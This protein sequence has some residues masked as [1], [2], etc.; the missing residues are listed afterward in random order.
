MLDPT[1]V[2][3]PRAIYSPLFAEIVGWGKCLPPATLSN[4]DLSTFLDTTDDW[5]LRRTGIRSR[6]ISHAPVSELAHVAALH[7]LAAAGLRPEDLELVVLGSCTADEQMPNTSSR[8]QRSI[9]AR[10]AAAVDVNTACT[11]FMYAMSYA[12]ALIRTGT[13]ETALVVGADT[14]SAYMDWNDRR[15]SVVFGDGAGAVVLRATDEPVGILA[16]KLGC[17]TEQRDVLRI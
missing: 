11:S 5:I 6:P 4:A 14:L 1:P 12:S 8:I 9:G 16:E 13:I 2:S 10:R 7:A 3:K 17:V 15:P